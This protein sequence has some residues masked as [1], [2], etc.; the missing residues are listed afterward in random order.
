MFNERQLLSLGKLL[1]AILELDVDLPAETPVCLTGGSAQAGENVR[2]LLVITFS[3]S[4]EFHNMLCDYLQTR[5]HIGKLFRL[6][7]YRPPQNPV[8]NN[9]WG[10]DGGRGTYKSEFNKIRDGKFYNLSAFEKY[11]NSGK[12]LEKPS[13]IKI[14]GKIGDLF[15]SNGNIQLSCG[16]SSYLPIPD[17]SV[18]AIITDPPYY[19]NVMYSELSEFYYAWLRLALKNKY[20]YFQSEHVPNSAEVIVNRVQEK[21]EKDFIEGLTAIFKEAG[22]KLKKDGV[23]TFTF[24]HQEERAWGAVLQS[25]L[26]A[27]FY[28]GSIYPVQSESSVSPHIFQKANVRYDMVIVCKKRESEPERKHWSVLEDEIYFKVEDE[29]KRLERHKKNLSSEDIFVVTIG[30]CL[31]VYSKHFPEVYKGEKRVSIEEAL[32]SI[33]EIV[34]SQLMHTRFNQ[35]AQET[36]TLTAIYL[37]YLAGKTS[38]SYESLNKALKMRSLRIGEVI[39]AGLVEREGS[40]LLVLTPSERKEVLE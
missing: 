11:I 28:I 20:E 8:E 34:D 13:K 29:L 2:E 23:M 40:Q 27:G 10:S 32:S 4:L 26:N 1:K 35:V 12:T 18:D 15:N 14:T 9:V 6:H 36:D 17:N 30:K 38:I 19:G 5:N 21:E 33:R 31:E 39:S 25:V 24:H 37:F 16:D 3:D 7:A 22:R